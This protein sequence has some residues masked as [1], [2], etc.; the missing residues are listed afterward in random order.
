MTAMRA[1]FNFL[2]STIKYN[3]LATLVW[4]F[5]IFTLSCGISDHGVKEKNDQLA[6]AVPLQRLKYLAL[7]DSYTIGQG[8]E[9]ED[10]FPN[11]L[12][13]SLVR[14]QFQVKPMQIIARTG[15]STGQLLEA[16]D[17][18]QA[19]TAV[20]DLVTLLIGVNNQYRG[21]GLMAY[22][23][24]FSELLLRAV[25][26]AGGRKSR[27]FVLSIPDYAVT[28]YGLRLI[29]A[30]ITREIDA[31]NAANRE[32]TEAAGVAYIDI[33]PASRAAAGN[34]KLIADDGLHPSG[35]MYRSWMRLLL[36]SVVQALQP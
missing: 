13:D 32:I 18:Q 29:P 6:P 8:V 4:S 22:R 27:V 30:T 2:M 21:L 19:D 16:I 35:L 36:P 1:W 12:R 28:P 17:A 33:T 5:L 24:E 10:R 23:A 15:W 31:Y 7:G 9:I 25:R 11:Q 34:R 20:W 26:L 14:Y 3:K